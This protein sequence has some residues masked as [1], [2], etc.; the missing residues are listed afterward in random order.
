MTAQHN[1]RAIAA[2]RLFRGLVIG[3]AGIAIYGQTEQ[4][5]AAKTEYLLAEIDL[6]SPV[7]A[8]M[9]H[10]LGAPSESLIGHLVVICLA[11]ALLLFV[12]AYGLWKGRHWAVWLAFLTSVFVSGA[13]ASVA[14]PIFG[15]KTTVVVAGNLMVAVY[16]LYLL[17]RKRTVSQ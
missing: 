7:M 4:S 1:L 3:A 8:L 17:R 6:A 16:L 5:L 9:G 11:W 14:M 12:Q 15:V 13:I 10:A 2:F